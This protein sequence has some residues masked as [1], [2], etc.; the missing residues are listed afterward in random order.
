MK[1]LLHLQ[2]Q[3]FAVLFS[4]T[5]TIGNAALAAT[6]SEFYQR[7]RIYLNQGRYQK[8]LS[9]FE[10]A[11]KSQLADTDHHLLA[12][13]HFQIANTNYALEAFEKA[14]SEYRN[15]I[16]LNPNSSLYYNSLGITHSQLKQYNKALQA[17]DKALQVSPKYPQPHYNIGLVYLKQ[18][19]YQSAIDAFKRAIIIDNKWGDP[20]NGIAEAYIKQGLLKR[21]EKNYTKALS[22]NPSNLTA[23]MGLAKVYA[24][25]ELLDDAITQFQRVIEIQTDNTDAYYQLAQIHIQRGEKDKAATFMET[26]KLLRDTDPLLHKAH[27]YVKMNPDDPRGYNNLGIVYLTRMQYDKALEYYNHAITLSPNLATTHY[28]IGL[29]YHKQAKIKLAIIAYQR[30]ITVDP[31]LAIAHNNIAVCYTD[32]KVNLNKALSH[33]QTATNIQPND[34]NYWDTL[35][36]VYTHLGQQNM[37]Q[38]ARQKQLELLNKDKK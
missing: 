1:A 33:A 21:A 11:I 15:A 9:S 20:Y 26:F 17:F 25:Q 4:I 19:T 3:I 24:K 27:K 12:E 8:A 16:L 2:Y 32:L 29:A 7:G 36:T 31:T 18:G 6:V 30:A 13:V 14:I 22:L 37:A 34:A 35:A 38:Q 10:N 5:C 28:N 23:N